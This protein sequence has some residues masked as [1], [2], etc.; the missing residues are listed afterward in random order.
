MT[1]P[2]QPTQSDIHEIR[3]RM[4]RW[5]TPAFRTTVEAGEMDGTGLYHR[6][7]AEMIRERKMEEQGDE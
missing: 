6:A 1:S 2:N 3:Q 4:L 7:E 5:L